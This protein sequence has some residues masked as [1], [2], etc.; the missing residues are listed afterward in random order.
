MRLQTSPE[1]D[2][3]GEA[4]AVYSASDVGTAGEKIFAAPI[5]NDTIV[6]W[7]TPFSTEREKEAFPILDPVVIVSLYDTVSKTGVP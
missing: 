5:A 2:A 3:I 1:T 7:I 6:V 4:V